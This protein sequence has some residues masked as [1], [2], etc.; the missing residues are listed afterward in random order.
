MD[1]I[2]IETF[3]KRVGIS[4]ATA[5]DWK[6]RN[7]LVLGRHYIK[8]GRVVRV[9]WDPDLI[10]KLMEDCAESFQAPRQVP[11]RKDVAVSGAG[12][13]INWEYK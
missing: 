9:C 1:L 5:F 4:R 8:F 11:R 10:R 2:T 3:A 13:T 6:R 7:I 12:S